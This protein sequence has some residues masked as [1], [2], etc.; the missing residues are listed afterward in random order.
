MYSLAS[1]HAVAIQRLASDPDFAAALGVPHPCRPEHAAA[2]VARRAEAQANGTSWTFAIV[3]QGEVVG[4]CSLDQPYGDEPRIGYWVGQLYERKGYGSFA[5]KMV[6]EFAFKNLQL[7]RVVSNADAENVAARRILENHGFA[8]DESAPSTYS[9]TRERWQSLRNDRALGALH[10]SLRT[11]LEEELAAGN[12]VVETGAGWPDP[13]SI[14]VRLRDQF[15][16]RPTTLPS[17]VEYTELNDPHWW[18]AEYSSASPR[19]ILAC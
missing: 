5:M 13:D 14:F 1:E 7:P 19:H 4:I 11:I 12:A 6:L 16:T 10:P 8:T 17:G 3:D 2:F 15:R 18:K 9:L